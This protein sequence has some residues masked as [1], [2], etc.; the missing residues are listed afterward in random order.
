MIDTQTKIKIFSDKYNL[1]DLVNEKLGSV[2]HN[3]NS[4]FTILVADL[5]D[6]LSS[7]DIKFQSDLLKHKKALFKSI[8]YI[9]DFI[10]TG[11]ALIDS[12]FYTSS[13][14]NYELYINNLATLAFI[15][16]KIQ[17][18]LIELPFN[19]NK[20]VIEA[21]SSIRECVKKEIS[22]KE[23][24]R[25]MEDEELFQF[26]QC[27]NS[28][29]FLYFGFLSPFINNHTKLLIKHFLE[30]YVVLD[31]ILDDMTD[32][33]QDYLNNNVNLLLLE[34]RVKDT[35]SNYTTYSELI[36]A[37]INRDIYGSLIDLIHKY[38]NLILKLLG[39]RNDQLSKYL[40]FL[41]NG[42]I[43]GIRIFKN[44]EYFI[45]DI[46]NQKKHQAVC[47]FLFKPYPWTVISYDEVFRNDF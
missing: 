3:N 1:I 44:N 32:V 25:I 33:C 36:N 40:K 11:D 16:W 15:P 9:S 8:N 38:Y 14:D 6:H 43:E 29:F 12:F 19:A 34:L 45:K 10:T 28:D 21:L 4:R 18:Y 26:L 39:D 30:L 23:S 31:T 22:L 46:V 37:L 27:R 42:C 20:S 2:V 13:K 7:D 41:A 35:N 5:I 24:P 47:K 17:K